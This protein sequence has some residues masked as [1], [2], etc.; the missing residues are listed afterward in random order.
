MAKEIRYSAAVSAKSI[1]TGLNSSNLMHNT[2]LRHFRRLGEKTRFNE[3]Y[4]TQEKNVQS[5]DY[6]LNILEKV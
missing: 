5:E 1:S 6:K 3:R 4:A 2:M